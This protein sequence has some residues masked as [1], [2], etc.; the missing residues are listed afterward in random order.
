MKSM[1]LNKVFGTSKEDKRRPSDPIDLVKL[2]KDS[3]AYKQIKDH[4]LSYKVIMNRVNK[5][6]E[7]ERKL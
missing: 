3:D 4:P 1:M 2:N 7:E 5:K 6:A